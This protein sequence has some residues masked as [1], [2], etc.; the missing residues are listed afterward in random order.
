MIITLKPRTQTPKLFLY[1][2]YISIYIYIL[3][4]F[5]Y[6]LIWP[7]SSPYLK[8]SGWLR[9]VWNGKLCFRHVSNHATQFNQ[10][11]PIL[12]CCSVLQIGFNIDL[13]PTFTKYN[14]PLIWS[15]Y[16][17][18]SLYVIPCVPCL[19]RTPCLPCV[20]CVPCVQSVRL[21]LFPLCPQ[22]LL[23]PL[24]LLAHHPASGASFKLSPSL[25]EIKSVHY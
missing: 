16:T 17:P 20:L 6:P 22:Y 5:S 14:R 4:I 12:N 8:L 13:Q 15:F 3:Y 2:L 7:T 9:S 23:C 1:I 10:Y 24:C 21:A 25:F 19:P 11:P 18:I